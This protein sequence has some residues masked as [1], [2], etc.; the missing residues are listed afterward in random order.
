MCWQGQHQGIALVCLLSLIM[1]VLSTTLVSPFF[2]EDY[3]GRTEI[4][5]WKTY[6]LHDRFWKTMLVLAD[7]VRMREACVVEV[8]DLDLDL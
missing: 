3:T 7:V 2:M 4:T 1:Y 6:L 8:F 5:F